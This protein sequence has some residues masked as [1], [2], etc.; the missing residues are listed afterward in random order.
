MSD[1]HDRAV[2]STLDW[3]EVNILQTRKFNKT[4]QIQEA[5]GDQKMIAALFKHDISRNEDPQLHT[6]CVVANAVL[7]NDGKYRSL[8]SPELFRN[9]M[10][11]GSIYRSE[12]AMN[13]QEAKLAS[14][15]RTHPDG[16]FELSGFDRALISEFSTRSKDIAE[17]LGEGAHSACLLYTSPSP[18]D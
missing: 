2:K 8:H 1:A 17:Y 13:I 4:A 5:V 7:G 9:K 6:H 12:L 16:R 18:R 11:I 15:T 14:I 10:L 3:V